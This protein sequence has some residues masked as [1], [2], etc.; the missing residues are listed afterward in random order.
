[1]VLTITTTPYDY[2]T[3]SHDFPFFTDFTYYTP[4]NGIK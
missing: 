3:L 4:F 2:D 1:M